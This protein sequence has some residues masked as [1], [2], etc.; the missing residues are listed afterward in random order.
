MSAGQ[1][2]ASDVTA[3]CGTQENQNSFANLKQSL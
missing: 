1:F 3:I 2:S